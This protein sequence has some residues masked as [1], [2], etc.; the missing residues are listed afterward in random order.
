MVVEHAISLFTIDSYPEMKL[1][2]CKDNANQEQFKI[3][4][5]IFI[6]EMPPALSKDSA[7]LITLACNSVII[8]VDSFLLLVTLL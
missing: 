1:I 5:F 7:S 4:I 2:F 8:F 6:A 3:N